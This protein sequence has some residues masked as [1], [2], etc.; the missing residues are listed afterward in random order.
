[1]YLLGDG[2]CYHELAGI[3]VQ[4]PHLFQFDDTLLML[5][6]RSLVSSPRA[7]AGFKIFPASI[8]PSAEPAPTSK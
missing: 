4:V 2:S 1:M 6:P 3:D 7:K 8:E 5:L